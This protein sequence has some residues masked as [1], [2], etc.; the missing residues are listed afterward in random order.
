MKPT[1]TGRHGLRVTVRFHGKVVGQTVHWPW[2]NP[3][4]GVSAAEA[5]P[6]EGDGL[7]RLRW[8]A[9]DR[10]RLEPLSPAVH[11]GEVAIGQG[12]RW[13]DGRDVDVDLDL[14]PLQPAPK[15]E[16]EAGDM[17]LLAL[18]LLLS[19]AVGQL[20]LLLEM[21]FGAVAPGVT[22]GVEP[23]PEYI[24]RLLEQDYD[25]AEEGLSERTE[26]PEHQTGVQSFY[27]PAGNQGPLDRTGGG[28][29]AGDRVSRATPEEEGEDDLPAEE[30][31]EPE[32]SGQ[33]ELLADAGKPTEGTPGAHEDED[34]PDEQG[35]Q[36]SPMERFVGWGFRDWFDVRDSRADALEQ[37]LR[38][39]LD[40]VRQRLRIDP[41]DPGAINTLGYYAYLAENHALGEET[42]GRLVA[43]YPD[44]PA[45]YNNL[46]LVYKRLGQY[47]KE[48]AL[49]RQALELDPLDEHVLNN[50]A[51]NLAHQG[52][53]DEAHQL[54]D[55]L[56]EVSPDDPY[57]DLHRAKIYAA[58]GKRQKAY[59]FLEQALQGAA[60]L[61][62]MH[63]IEFRQ[64]IRLDPA[65]DALRGEERFARVLRDAYGEDA[66][67][68][69]RGPD[70]RG[71]NGG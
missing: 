48:E 6:T 9:A 18:V 46:G 63:H 13:N 60:S 10:V 64:D 49:Y 8:E 40:M 28:A 1:T 5:V 2:S 12:W 16:R 26:R 14:V 33:T 59:R 44:E 11:A 62:T 69:L 43:M 25:G 30:P 4:V 47:E 32:L 53:F 27:M 70:R 50:L 29:V 21:F 23:T 41:D 3:V 19:V 39:E 7:V 58:Q 65:F 24:A 35:G 38:R 71:G 42:F 57:A 37:Q 55:L 22:V 31:E 20:N 34:T 66:T 52:R 68:L 45:G 56:E 67:E 17:A 61:D 51:V 36:P 54:M 15:R